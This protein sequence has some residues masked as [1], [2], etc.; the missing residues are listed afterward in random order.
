MYFAWIN[1]WKRREGNLSCNENPF[2]LNFELKTSQGKDTCFWPWHSRKWA[3]FK[4]W[5]QLVWCST[6]FV[7]L[8]SNCNRVTQSN[9][10]Q[11]NKHCKLS[12]RH[13]P[14]TDFIIFNTTRWIWKSVLVNMCQISGPKVLALYRK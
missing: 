9:T 8:D 6:S 13:A 10:N 7:N 2:T 11:I 4:C 5:R 12:R 3:L 1:A 14:Q